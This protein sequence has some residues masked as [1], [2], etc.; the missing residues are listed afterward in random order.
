MALTNAEW[1]PT[2]HVLIRPP[3][4]LLKQTPQGC[5]L[6]AGSCLAEECRNVDVRNFTA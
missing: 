5:E 4:F 6:G 2:R 1:Q 3:L